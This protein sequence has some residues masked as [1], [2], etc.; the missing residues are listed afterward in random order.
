MICGSPHLFQHITQSLSSQ[1]LWRD[2]LYF[3]PSAQEQ[4]VVFGEHSV[5]KNRPKGVIIKIQKRSESNVLTSFLNLQKARLTTDG[6]H[7]L[8]EITPDLLQWSGS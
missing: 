3:L 7:L 5:L 4:S 8:H 1:C 2:Q 6:T